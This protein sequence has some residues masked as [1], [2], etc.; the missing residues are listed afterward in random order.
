MASPSDFSRRRF[1]TSMGSATLVLG[2]L[3]SRGATAAPIKPRNLVFILVDDMRFDAMGFMND[4]Y[5]TPHLDAL[6]K[7]GMVFENCFVA[8]SLCSPSRASILSGQFAHVHGVLDNSTPLPEG[9]PTFPQE[10]QKAGY[11][12]AFIG[13]WHM[14]GASDAPRPGFK[15]WVSFKGQGQY[16]DQTF[17]INGEQVPRTGHTT[18]IVADYAVDFLKDTGADPFCL[19]LSHKAVHAHF[20]PPERYKGTYAD[21]KFPRPA[22]MENSEENYQ[23]KPEW[24]RRQRQSWHGVDGMYD[25]KMDFDT[26]VKSYPE[27]LR[28]VDDSVGRVV[29]TLRESGKLDDTLILFTSDNGFQFGEHGLIDKRTMYEASIKVP[30]IAHCPDMI[31]G[32][33]RR[34]EL[35]Q[36]IDFAPTL[37]EAAGQPIPDTIQGRS[38]LDVLTGTE[39]SWRD[40][41]LY[42]YF[43]ERAFPHTPTVLGVRTERYKFMRYHGVWDRYELYDLQEDP[44][45]MNNLLGDYLI[46]SQAGQLDS[47]IRRTAPDPLKSLFNEMN[48][49]L[50][51]LLEQTKSAAEPNWRPW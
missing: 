49:K 2:A 24:V 28:A 14:G 47:L 39:K 40:A 33:Q 42:E 4:Y 45:E 48:T 35:V 25:E 13:K 43:W 1:L 51:T 11:N 20:D 29:E 32:G 44:D 16:R 21:K 10:L 5:E 36:N 41:I 3:G 12:T 38:F 7:N 50:D 30:L 18:D 8:T 31:P 9:T 23:G 27:L 37:L 46:E 34:T 19:Y 15:H 6:A 22:S 17:N 26:F